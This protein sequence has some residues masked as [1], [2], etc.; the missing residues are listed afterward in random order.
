LRKTLRILSG[1]GLV[2]IGI[3]GLIMP[4]MPGWVFL[5]PGLV[6][7]AEYFPPVQRL[8][9]WAKQTYEKHKTRQAE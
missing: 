7:L 4:I 2:I 9:D 8:L 6:I 1:L 5:I 3:I